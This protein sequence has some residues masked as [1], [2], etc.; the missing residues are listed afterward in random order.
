MTRIKCA[1]IRYDGMNYML[2]PPKR[3][4][5]IIAFLDRNGLEDVAKK[6]EQ[7]F[8]TDEGDFVRRRPAL[9]IA[10]KAGQIKQETAPSHGLFSEDI[11]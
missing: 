8:M 10:R 6:G 7:G 4:H 9:R 3:H 11:F 2:D 5:D 1:A